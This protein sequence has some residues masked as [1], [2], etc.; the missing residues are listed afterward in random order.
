MEAEYWEIWDHIAG[1]TPFPNTTRGSEYIDNGAGLSWQFSIP[2]SDSLTF[3]NT[4]VFSPLLA[5][6]QQCGSA[7]LDDSTDRSA[8]HGVVVRYDSRF[9]VPPNEPAADATAR[10][11]AEAI[12]DRADRALTQYANL[13]FPVTERRRRYPGSGPKRGQLRSVA[14]ADACRFPGC[15]TSLRRR[16]ATEG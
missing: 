4:T 8:D 9:I 12:R 16:R 13:G 6:S 3:A 11:I 5:T 15:G 10:V 7:T 14:H 1:K 2:A